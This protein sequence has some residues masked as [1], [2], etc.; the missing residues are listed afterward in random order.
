[1]DNGQHETATD[2]HLITRKSQRDGKT[3]GQNYSDFWVADQEYLPLCLGSSQGEME[4]CFMTYVTFRT[5]SSRHF[6]AQ[7]R[8]KKVCGPCVSP[9]L[10]TEAI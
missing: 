9:V 2:T 3:G 10:S 4:S 6:I 7:P 1:M 8:L 5:A